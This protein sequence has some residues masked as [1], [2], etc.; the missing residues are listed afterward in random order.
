MKKKENLEIN[1]SDFEEVKSEEIEVTKKYSEKQFDALKSFATI[2]A[3]ILV[4]SLSKGLFDF[5]PSKEKKERK[6]TMEEKKV[7]LV[8][9]LLE[10]GIDLAIFDSLIT[11]EINRRL[12]TRFG[13]TFL[14]FTFIVTIASY[15][16]VVFDAIYKWGISQ[17]AITALIIEIPIQFIGLLYIIAKNLFPVSMDK[18]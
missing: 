9:S 5:L 10:S 14:I 15:M 6:Q 12:K 8:K 7:D 18:K 3:E 1:E 2:L 11:N 13:I 17:V 4:P 16:I